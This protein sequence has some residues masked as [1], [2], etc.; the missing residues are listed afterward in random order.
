M[1]LPGL[2]ADDPCIMAR[3]DRQILIHNPGM[4]AGALVELGERMTGE[5]DLL[6]F[7]VPADKARTVMDKLT[8]Q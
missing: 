4:V 6:M 8:G 7:A 2:D 3:V 5:W 1:L